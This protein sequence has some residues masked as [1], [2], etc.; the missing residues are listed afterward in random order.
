MRHH[1]TSRTLAASIYIA[2]FIIGVMLSPTLQAQIIITE[3][4]R[5]PRGAESSLTGGQSYEFIEIT[6]IGIDTV[7]LT[8]LLLTTGSS[9]D[10]IIAID[11]PI[12]GHETCTYAHRYLAP[13]TIALILDADYRATVAGTQN[14]RFAISPNTVMLQGGDAAFGQSGLTS[15]DGITLFRGTKKRIDTILCWAADAPPDLSSPTTERLTL[16]TPRDIEGFSLI[17][18]M[19]L[20]QHIRFDYC[21]DSISPGRFEPLHQGWILEWRLTADT[22]NTAQLTLTCNLFSMTTPLPAPTTWQLSKNTQA[23][24]VIAQ[25]ALEPD[26]RTTTI[27]TTVSADSADLTFALRGMPDH[28]NIALSSVFLPEKSVQ[29]TELFPKATANEPEWFEIYNCTGMAIDLKNWQF[30]NSESMDT[31]TKTTAIL[32]PGRFNI[33]CKDV[34]QMKSLYPTLRRPLQPPHW[35]TLSNSRDTV[36]LL[37]GTGILRETICY[38][39]AWFSTWDYRSLERT[40]SEN[41]CTPSSWSVATQATPG[42]PNRALLWHTNGKPTME[43]GPI[44]FTPDNDRTDDLLAIR[45]Q[46]PAATSFSIQIF[47]F[48][49]RLLK[50]FPPQITE[51]FYWDGRDDQGGTAPVGPFFVVAAIRTNSKTERIRKKGVLW[52]K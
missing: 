19:V 8:N 22:H 3:L 27:T 50:T 24:P 45:L 1:T 42:V 20:S 37:D 7:S 43:I 32:E 28:W 38:D 35:H 6:N 9:V 11:A 46:F 10:T 23:Q 15:T 30:G 5:N 16:A 14:R 41:G 52:R 25:G 48:D 49:G 51:I 40:S 33:I 31:L 4:L 36:S 21:P 44:P 17:A 39:Q 18:Q 29:I 34:D 12:I 2:W 13:G 26:K 47:Q